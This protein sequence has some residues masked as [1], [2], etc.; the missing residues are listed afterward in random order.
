MTWANDYIGQK[1]KPNGRGDD[2][3]DCWGLVAKVFKDQ[4]DLDLPHWTVEEPYTNSGA[5]RALTKAKDESILNNHAEHV[6]KPKDFDIAM[7][8]RRRVAFHVGVICNGGVLHI[9]KNTRGATWERLDEF[10]KYGGKLEVYR[11]RP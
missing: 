1:W 5:K 2:G 7:L 4:L 3:L 8:V 9:S 10:E 6:I 11:W